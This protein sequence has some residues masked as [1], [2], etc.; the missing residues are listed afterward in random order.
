MSWGSVLAFAAPLVGEAVGLI[1]K[2]IAASKE[3]RAALEK[4]KD[5]AI[6]EMKAAGTSEAA[7]H[8]AMTAETLKIIAE[9]DAAMDAAGQTSPRP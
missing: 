7:A 2:Y 6:A 3:Q 4:R 1:G 9:A 5:A 8:D